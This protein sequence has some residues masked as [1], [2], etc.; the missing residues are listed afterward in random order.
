MKWR[1]LIRYAVG[2]TAA[3]AVGVAVG[4]SLTLPDGSG[5]AA[6]RPHGIG[7]SV[8]AAGV[9]NSQR[10]VTMHAHVAGLVPGRAESAGLKSERLADQAAHAHGD[11]GE[12]LGR[13]SGTAQSFHRQLRLPAPACAQVCR[14]EP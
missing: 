10:S 2:Y 8:T 3:A 12:R 1:M 5:Q 13:L 9:T 6:S 4:W 14:A 7:T 11:S